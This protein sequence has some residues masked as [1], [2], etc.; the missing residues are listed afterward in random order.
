MTGADVLA[1]LYEI[2]DPNAR[3][4]LLVEAVQ[5]G[6]HDPLR[7]AEVESRHGPRVATFRVALDPLRIAGKRVSVSARTQQRIADA[8]G[9]SLPTPKLL[10]LRNDS[11]KVRVRPFTRTT[12]GMSSAEAMVEASDEIDRRVAAAIADGA[13]EDGLRTL[14]SKSWVITRLGLD[15]R[16]KVQ[17]MGLAE[18]APEGA[19]VHWIQLPQGYDKAH[20]LLHHDYSQACELLLGSCTVDGE[21]M[22]VEDVA[23][24]PL[25]WPLLC[26]DGPLH[27]MR[28]DVPY[29]EASAPELPAPLE[30]DWDAVPRFEP[31]FYGK[32][33]ALEP[34]LVVI[35]ATQGKEARGAAAATMRWFA[36][37]PFPNGPASVHFCVDD[38]AIV[39]GVPTDRV[40]YGAKGAN[41][42]G[43]HVEIV[44]FSEQGAAGWSDA[45][46]DAALLR[47]AAVVARELRRSS[48][49]LRWV[50]AAELRASYRGVRGIATHASV[51]RGRRE[52]THTDPGPAFPALRFLR[53]V[54][55]A[56]GASEPC[57]PT[58]P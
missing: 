8:L 38:S 26:D 6:L 40:A 19:P 21:D 14:C 25:L 37:G 2:T 23:K 50:T 45:Y 1:A 47:A 57:P 29:A 22:L 7:W 4:Q 10:R 15:W 54:E 52:S 3:D 43:V 49:P 48:I 55:A 18:L 51:S 24:H 17:N 30:V 42:D 46:S 35:H 16:A 32:D 5:L 58:L 11:A 9:C 44:G 56:L 39:A 41:H 31:L 34:S 13:P 53:M 33:R 36:T 27:G 12:V 28:L 20:D